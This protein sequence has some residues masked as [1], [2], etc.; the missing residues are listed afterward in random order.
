VVS[1]ADILRAKILVVDDKEANVRLLEGMLRVAGYV[2]VESTMDPAAV[3]EMYRQNRY[4]LILLDLQMPGMDGFQVMDGLKE[5]EGDG[6]LPVIAITAQPAHKLRALRAGAKDFVGKPF[7][8]AEL[9]ARVHNIVEVRLLHQQAKDSQRMLEETVRELEGSRQ[10][11]KAEAARDPLTGLFNRRYME[12][13]FER[14]LHR[15]VREGSTIGIIMLDVDHFKQFNDTFGHDGGDTI[16]KELSALLLARTREE[17]IVCRYG[18]EE[19]LIVLPGA[20][21]DDTRGR[22]EGLLAAIR[23]MA[24]S[25]HG[26]EVKSNSASIGVAAYPKNGDTVGSLIRAADEALYQAKTHGRDCAR[27]A[28]AQAVPGVRN[29]QDGSR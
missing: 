8:M 17:D 5:I 6:Y 18:G 14:D 13:T 19:F 25:L 9:C 24:V 2:S 4:G 20:S 15:A 12:A 22:A 7:D 28:A 3:H 29:P 27:V 26:R 23:S 21:L 10:E 1:A 11:L 16:L